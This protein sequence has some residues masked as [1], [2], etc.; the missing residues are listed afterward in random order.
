MEKIKSKIK[1]KKRNVLE[2]DMT[3]INLRHV[4]L[5]VIIWGNIPTE[6]TYFQNN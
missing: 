1:N 5:G 2:L 4:L 6:K 3:S